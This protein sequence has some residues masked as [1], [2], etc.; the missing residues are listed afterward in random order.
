MNGIGE[1]VDVL[2]FPHWPPTQRALS[3]PSALLPPPPVLR[4]SAATTAS[5]RVAHAPTGRASPHH[6]RPCSARW[7]R[8][9]TAA[10]AASVAVFMEAW[11]ARWV[12]L[13]RLASLDRIL[14]RLVRVQVV[15]EVDGKRVLDEVVHQRRGSM[16]E[17]TCRLECRR[18]P[19]A[20]DGTC[21]GR[22]ARRAPSRA[23]AILLVPSR[24]ARRPESSVEPCRSNRRPRRSARQMLM[25]RGWTRGTIW[26]LGPEIPHARAFRTDVWSRPFMCSL[27]P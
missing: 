5:P 16:R 6:G 27:R 19:D 4:R 18:S 26:L 23:T 14:E 22:H 25:H 24:A 13:P 7:R 9:A 2:A 12:S 21:R 3:M 11:A 17:L 8:A 20:R 1:H 15:E 10:S